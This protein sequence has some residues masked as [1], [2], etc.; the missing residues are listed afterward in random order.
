VFLVSLTFQ[1]DVKNNTMRR[2]REREKERRGDCKIKGDISSSERNWKFMSVA[3]FSAFPKMKF[4]KTE[5]LQ[6]WRACNGITKSEPL[7]YLNGL[8]AY[9]IEK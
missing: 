6:T 9:I 2:E 8:C 7:F 5:S 4:V 1:I 3:F